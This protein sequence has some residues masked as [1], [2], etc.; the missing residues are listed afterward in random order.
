MGFWP[1][2]GVASSASLLALEAEARRPWWRK[3]LGAGLLLSLVA[4]S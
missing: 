1:S 2:C 3:L 4:G